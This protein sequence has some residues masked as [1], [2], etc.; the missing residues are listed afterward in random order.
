M[1]DPFGM[2]ERKPVADPR[3]TVMRDDSEPVMP[4]LRH[5]LDHVPGHLAFG[6]VDMLRIGRGP[7]TRSVTAEVGD[8]Q[9]KRIHQQRSQAVPLDMRLRESVQQ[10]QRVAPTADAAMDRGILATDIVCRE[11]LEHGHHSQ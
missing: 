8:D 5:D 10:Q 6:V 11:S 7:Q 9:R 4:D 2:I 3:P 1:A